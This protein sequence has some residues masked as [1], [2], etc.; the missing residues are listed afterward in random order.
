MRRFTGNET[1]DAQTAEISFKTGKNDQKST[2]YASK[3]ISSSSC[4]AGGGTGGQ[5][6]QFL[7]EKQRISL[8]RERRAARTMGVV[9]GAFVL[10]WLPFF[11]VYVVFAFCQSCKDSTN[12]QVYN[13]IVWLGYINS[14]LNPL[15]YTVFNID[16]RRAFTL[17][18]RCRCGRRRRHGVHHR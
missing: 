17:L 1:I 12:P 2:T 13:F 3:S 14:T 4:S 7:E 18:L 9:M 15:I 11:V 6:W 10:C 5:I 8:A 16:F